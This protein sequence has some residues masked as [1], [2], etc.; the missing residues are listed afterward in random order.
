MTRL[1]CLLGRPPQGFDALVQG[2][3]RSS[4]A[5]TSGKD[6]IAD[7]DLAIEAQANAARGVA[8]DVCHRAVPGPNGQFH[9]VHQ[10]KVTLY[11]KGFCVSGMEANL[12]TGCLPHLLQRTY[13]IGMSVA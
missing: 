10:G 9:V 5:W 3:R 6:S 1:A 11:A 8:R 13:V 4:V 12:C 2:F 7:Y